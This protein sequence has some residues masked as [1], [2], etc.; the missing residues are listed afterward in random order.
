MTIQELLNETL[1]EANFLEEPTYFGPSTTL[2]ARQIAALVNRERN[3]LA[4]YE[5]NE[6][7]RFQTIT[8]TSE[9]TYDLPTDYRQ[10][11]FD[12]AFTT[13]RKAWFPVAPEKWNYDNARNTISGRAVEVRLINNK[14]EVRNP[15]PGV[16]FRL[17]YVS[18]YSVLDADGTTLKE[19]F[20]ADNDTFV[21]NDELLTA[22]F[23]WRFRKA[24]GLDFQ[25]EL[26]EAKAMEKREK[27]TNASAQTL[28]FGDGPYYGP[29][30]PYADLYV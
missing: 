23:L 8:L 5:W 18:K 25:A 16:E 21:L 14:L 26:A 13:D 30:A 9:T 24:K 1:S 20:E 11:V 22:G 29:V 4:K 17:E 15:E 6:L 19:R 7:I 10:Y 3:S 2:E 12:T 27:S 28:Y